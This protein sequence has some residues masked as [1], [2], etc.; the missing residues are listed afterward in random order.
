[1]EGSNTLTRSLIIFGQGLMRSHPQLYDIVKSVESNNSKEFNKLL[2][3][4]I[5]DNVKKFK[6]NNFPFFTCKY[7][8]RI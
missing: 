8:T 6:Q 7:E 3:L 5:K 1:M 4:L 2:F